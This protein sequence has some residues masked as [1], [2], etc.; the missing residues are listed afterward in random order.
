MY[1][2][3]AAWW[4]YYRQD[5]RPIRR[6]IDP[7]RDAAERVAAEINAQLSAA[8]PTM[9]AFTPWTAAELRTAFLDY[10]EHLLRSSVASGPVGDVCR[11]IYQVCIR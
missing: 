11:L 8:A 6:R 9:F 7:D 10:H 1:F 3:H 4:I 2:H 5:D